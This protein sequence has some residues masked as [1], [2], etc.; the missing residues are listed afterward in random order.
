MAVLL[1]AAVGV[2][3]AVGLTVL[4]ATGAEDSADGTPIRLPAPRAEATI[5]TGPYVGP[6]RDPFQPPT[7]LRRRAASNAGPSPPP[8]TDLEPDDAFA[9]G[10][11]PF[12]GREAYV[13]DPPPPPPDPPWQFR[14]LVGDRAIFEGP[15]GESVLVAE[16]DRLGET[17][18]TDISPTMVTLQYQGYEFL[19]DAPMRRGL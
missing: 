9:G 18:V 4:R 7:D 13:P 15:D 3:V 6:L 2:W 19:Y 10:S 12:D 11:M 17:L 14:G 16:G 5:P 8:S 1:V